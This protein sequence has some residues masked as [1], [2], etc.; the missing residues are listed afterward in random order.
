[1]YS[2]SRTLCTIAFVAIC[3]QSSMA[4]WRDTTEHIDYHVNYWISAPVIAIRAFT[5]SKGLA[6]IRDKK[7]LTEA[8]I[9][10]QDRSKVPWFDRI[11]LN[12]H[13]YDY[14]RYEENSDF[15]LTWGT[16]APAILLAADRRM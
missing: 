7:F 9:L 16:L 11:A 1:M 4:Q 2:I 5:N 3:I 6:R 12:Q 15:A 8:E 14:D 13:S 10:N